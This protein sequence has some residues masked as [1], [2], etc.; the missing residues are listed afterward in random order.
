MADRAIVTG[1]SLDSYG[2]PL[3]LYLRTKVFF[4]RNT[5][6]GSIEREIDVAINA[7]DTIVQIGNKVASAVRNQGVIDQFDFSVN[8]SI[9]MPDYTKV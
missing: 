5:F 9:L 2:D 3:Q 7:T 8:G 1:Y 4:C 6:G